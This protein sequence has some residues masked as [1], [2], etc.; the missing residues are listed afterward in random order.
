MAASERLTL[1]KGEFWFGR[2]PNNTYIANPPLRLLGSIPAATLSREVTKLDHFN[3]MDGVGIKDDS[4]VTAT[5]YTGSLTLEDFALEN[6]ALWAA[7]DVTTVTDTSATGVSETFEDVVPGHLY[8]LG[9]S[10]ARPFGARRVTTV[11][12][13]SGATTY[14][15]GTDYR[16]DAAAGTIQVLV[17]GDIA[18]E[19][20]IT[21][22]YGITA[23]SRK[24]ITPG[25]FP[26][27]E[28]ALRFISK[29]PKGPRR[30]FLFP[31]VALTSDGEFSFIGDDW[32]NMPISLEI[33]QAGDLPP[34]LI[35]GAT[36]E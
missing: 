34:Y 21:V 26:Q 36:G 1:G 17:G 8:Q 22:E 13:E 27:V 5:N 19:S 15:A 24:L 11:T 2:F 35:D 10:N 3:P 6:M 31:R 12:V 28:G 14:V 32:G 9:V 18:A 7:G 33:L 25:T 30:N 23:G 4:V 20:D 16:L 29:N